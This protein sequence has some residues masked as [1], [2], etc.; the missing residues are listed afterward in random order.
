VQVE[1]DGMR[2]AE[3]VADPSLM[4]SGRAEVAKE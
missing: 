2:E 3:G 1:V 4:A